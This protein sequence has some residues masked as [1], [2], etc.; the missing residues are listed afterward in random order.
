MSPTHLSCSTDQPLK[1]GVWPVLE[2]SSGVRI[3]RG[4]I[5]VCTS[6]VFLKVELVLYDY[7]V[8]V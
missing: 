4:K 6:L 7:E 1:L 8:E 2:V 5:G 3:H